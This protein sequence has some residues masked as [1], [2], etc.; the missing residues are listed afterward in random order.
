MG[1]NNASNFGVLGRRRRFSLSHH[2]RVSNI[3]LALSPIVYSTL[4]WLAI[5]LY[6]IVVDSLF[7]DGW[8][9]CSWFIYFGHMSPFCA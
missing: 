7:W 1:M 3:S 6:G 9:Y 2:P 5:I 4:A 8:L